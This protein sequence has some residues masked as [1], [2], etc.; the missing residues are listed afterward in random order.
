MGSSD[1]EGSQTIQVSFSILANRKRWIFVKDPGFETNDDQF[2][3][4]EQVCVCGEMND[5]EMK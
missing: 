2:A 3:E 4:L 5:D 1:K